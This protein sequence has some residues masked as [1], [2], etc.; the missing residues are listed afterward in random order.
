MIQ[1]KDIVVP[2]GL[3]MAMYAL[4]AL[5]YAQLPPGSYPIHWDFQGQPNGYADKLFALLVLPGVTTF[6]LGVFALKIRYGSGTQDNGQ[7]TPPQMGLA[8]HLAIGLITG[9]LLGVHTVMIAQYLHPHLPFVRMLTL[10][11]G[12]LFMM[13]GNI[14]PKIR[15]N[16]WIGLRL[17]WTLK[18]TEV[19]EKT[20]RLFGP[21]MVLASLLPILGGL[22]PLDD[23]L[24][25][26]LILFAALC[27]GLVAGLYGLKLSRDKAAPRA[28]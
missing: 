4:S 25:A 24:M 20:H 21:L 19:W 28:P 16:T 3:L 5:A 9:A 2:I 6:V 17:P 7:Q 22:S 1:N 10:I 11:L 27:P 18:D 23:T 12:V 15:Q 26:P 14:M 13:L 8:S